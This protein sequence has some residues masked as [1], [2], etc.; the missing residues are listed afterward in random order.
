MPTVNN[1]VPQVQS[2]LLPLTKGY[3]AIVDIDDFDAVN[4]WKWSATLT[5]G[6]VYAKRSIYIGTFNGKRKQKSVLLHRF[7]AGLDDPSKKV[8]HKDG[9]GLNCSKTNLRVCRTDTDNC[10]NSV[11]HQI[12]TSSSKYKGVCLY[13]RLGLWQ[14]SVKCNGVNYY[15]GLYRNEVDAAKAYDV[16]ARELF[17]EFARTNF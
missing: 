7:I 15:V 3:S 13:R 1:L 2:R 14:T 9:D 12:N 11:K 17:G 10:A 5:K 8:D 16:K 4:Q 6:K